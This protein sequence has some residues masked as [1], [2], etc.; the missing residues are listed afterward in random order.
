[1]KFKAYYENVGDP[2][3][4]TQTVYN[5]NGYEVKRI[6]TPGQATK[7]AKRGTNWSTKFSK[8]SRKYLQDGPLYVVLK[9]EMPVAQAQFETSNYANE[10]NEILND[11]TIMDILEQVKQSEGR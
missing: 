1:M 2:N 3:L 4:A 7:Y 10:K 5:E 6:H 8:F 11:P 9:D